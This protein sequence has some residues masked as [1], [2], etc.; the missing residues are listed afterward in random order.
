ML[1]S[2]MGCGIGDFDVERGISEQRV[3]GNALSGLLET[4]FDAPIPM[5]VNIE[6]ETA[7]RDTGPAKAARLT[8]LDFRI[9]P[10][11]MAAP[12]QD[13]FSFLQSVTVYVESTRAG[14][15][16]A[17]QKIAEA[18]DIEA[19][20]ALRFRT[21]GSVDLLPYTQEGARFVSE[22]QGSAPADDVTFAGSFTVTVELF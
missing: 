16:L 22:A 5:N 21:L 14:S 8:R 20:A 6:E 17:R 12:D 1:I 7:A 9:T 13:D 3:P 15:S 4:F 11:A 2:L 18:L 19:T 10:S